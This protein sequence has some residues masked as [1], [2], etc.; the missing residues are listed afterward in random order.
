MG[1]DRVAMVVDDLVGLR[2]RA[3]LFLHRRR[4]DLPERLQRDRRRYR[5]WVCVP[6]VCAA[7]AG[8]K[9]VTTISLPP[10]SASSRRTMCQVPLV[11][12]DDIII[13]MGSSGL[14]NG[15]SLV[16]RVLEV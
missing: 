1:L 2:R 11:K 5:R 4:S 8:R 10:A 3:A 15:Y 12:P 14:L 9:P 7:A 13:A 6:A 16:L